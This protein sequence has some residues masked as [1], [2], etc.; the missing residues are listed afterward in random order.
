MTDMSITR[1]RGDHYF[2][3][4]FYRHEFEWEG[5]NY[6][7]VEHAYQSMKT[8]DPDKQFRVRNCVTPGKAKSSGAH[9]KLRPDWE[10]VKDGIMLSIVEAKFRSPRLRQMLLATGDAQL[11]EGNNWGDRYWGVDLDT[12]EGENKLGK[13]LMLVRTQI[14]SRKI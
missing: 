1:F 9:L 12:G 3:S 8:L 10:E 7:T 4:N 2:L 14:T 5:E 13:I 11:I 6:L